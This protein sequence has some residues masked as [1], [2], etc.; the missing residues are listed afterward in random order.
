VS[1]MAVTKFCQWGM[2]Y[3]I[4]DGKLAW[5][6]TLYWSDFYRCPERSGNWRAR[7]PDYGLTETERELES[8]ERRRAAAEGWYWAQ[9]EGMDATS[10]AN[11]AIR[12]QLGIEG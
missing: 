10:V 11:R 6:D 3:R 4:S 7:H 9:R 2:P 12:R 1:A 8:R 5:P